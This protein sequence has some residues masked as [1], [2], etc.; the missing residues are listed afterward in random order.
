MS[1]DDI[2]TTFS[3][4]AMAFSMVVLLVALSFWR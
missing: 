2:A 1:L 4:I 3:I